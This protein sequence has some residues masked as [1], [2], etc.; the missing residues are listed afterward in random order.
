MA[1]KTKVTARISWRCRGCGEL[2]DIEAPPTPAPLCGSCGS[3][4]TP[5]DPPPEP[6]EVPAPKRIGGG[7]AAEVE[8]PSSYLLAL[9]GAVTKVAVRLEDHVNEH[10]QMTPIQAVLRVVRDG[11]DRHLEALL[12]GIE[13]EIARVGELAQTVR[14]EIDRRKGDAP[15]T[16][17]R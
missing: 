7:P 16:P 6:I 15:K 12:R 8:R 1:K 17:V 2:Q 9:Q 4:M 5:F 11:R 13:A 3:V 10:R 14:A